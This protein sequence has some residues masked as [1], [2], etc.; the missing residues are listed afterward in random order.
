[1]PSLRYRWRIP[2]ETPRFTV[3]FLEAA[4]LW[5]VTARRHRIA[6]SHSVERRLV[7]EHGCYWATEQAEHVQ[8]RCAEC[9][10]VALRWKARGWSF[11]PTTSVSQQTD[12]EKE[13][14][15]GINP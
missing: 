4:P 5:T 3:Q 8:S 14:Q 9:H 12:I 10:A 6:L 11:C 15:N 1:M 2:P 13:R 7:A